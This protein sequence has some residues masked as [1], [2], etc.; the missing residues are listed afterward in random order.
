M[1]NT[2][3]VRI[4]TGYAGILLATLIAAVVLTLNNKQVTHQVDSFVSETLPALSTL[5]NVQSNS[6]QLVLIGFSLYGTTL[7]GNAFDEQKQE[8]EQNVDAGFKA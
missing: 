2:I 4:L 7:S 8:L 3:K 1:L 6:K 5:D